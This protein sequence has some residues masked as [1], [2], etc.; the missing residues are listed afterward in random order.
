[1]VRRMRVL[2][3]LAH[4]CTESLAH[5]VA[6]TAT[7]ALTSA[8]HSVDVIDLYALDVRAEISRDEWNAYHGEDPLRDPTLIDHAERLRAAEALVFVYPTWW[9]STPAILKGWIE[10]L[11]VPGIGFAFDDARRVRPALT[12]VRRIVG[13]STYGSA[14]LYVKLINDNGRRLITRTLR[15]ACGLGTRSDWLALYSIDTA[16]ERQRRRFLARVER[17]M[18]AL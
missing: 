16:D 8:G 12:N 4:P 7:G 14:R 2:L 6:A 13:I 18:R 11:F 3:V 5:A 15:A 9:S 17:R 10:R 1:M